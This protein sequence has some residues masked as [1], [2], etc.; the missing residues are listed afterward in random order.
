M[1][2]REKREIDRIK[3]RFKVLSTESIN[4]ILNNVTNGGNTSEVESK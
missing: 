3:E 2:K 4:E 1:L